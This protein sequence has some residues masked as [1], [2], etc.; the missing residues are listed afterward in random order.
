[1]PLAVAGCTAG[2]RG[3]GAPAEARAAATWAWV[4]GFIPS[5]GELG[6]RARSL[7][8]G[9]LP[10]LGRGLSAVPGA[11]GGPSNAGWGADAPAASQALALSEA[12]TGH[13]HWQ[14]SRHSS[15]GAGGTEGGRQWP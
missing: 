4:G 14:L 11:S 5:R 15:H 10:R 9:P 13:W 1:M 7:G 2:A 3:G 12:R 8:S 6:R